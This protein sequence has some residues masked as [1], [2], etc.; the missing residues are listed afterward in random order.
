MSG[1][2]LS[3]KIVLLG[4]ARVG[5]TS[6]R[7]TFFGE[8]FQKPYEV[9]IGADFAAKRFSMPDKKEQ[10]WLITSNIWDLSGQNKFK[11]IRETYYKGVSGALMVYDIARQETFDS[12]KTWIN[13]LVDNN[14]QHMVPM[15]VIAN[16]ADLKLEMDNTIPAEMGQELAE[17]LTEEY[18]EPVQ[19]LEASAKTGHNVAA[20]FEMLISQIFDDFVT[21]VLKQ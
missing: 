9:T 4:D 19:F 1:N 7:R 12:I 21:T 3:C 16:K 18:N 14:K 2:S 17:K 13:E 6:L 15:V 10:S 8:G 20:S 5:K 11:I